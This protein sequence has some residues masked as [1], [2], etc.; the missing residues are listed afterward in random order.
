MLISLDWLKQYVDIKEDIKELDN[1][2]TMIGQE[3]EAIDIQGK[4]LD[5]VVI[6]HIVEY[7]KHPNSDKLT[8][9]KVNIGEEEPLQIVCGAPNHKLGDK[10]VV[11]KI[12][13]V[14]PG[15]FKIKKSKI[16]D[17]ESFGMLCSQVELGI[18]EDG[19]GII[20]LPEDAPIGVEY[21]KYAGL[22]DVI[23]EL[24]I[25]PNRPDCLSHIGIAREIAAYYGR[26]V[27]YPSVTYTEAIDP[28]TKV[29][30][31][32]IDDKDRCKRYMGRV[33]RN[34]TVGESPEWL[35]KRIRAMGLKP[36]NNV[37][38][39]T[40]FVMFEYN[41]PMHAFDL[42][43]VANGSIVV[44]EAK[45]GEK[46]T[47][48]DGVERELTNGEL[49]IADDE[50]AI[51]IAGIIGG[52]GTEITSETKNIFLEVAYFTPE[53]IRKTG[54]RLGISTDSSYRNERGIDIEGIP[55]ASERA[56]ALIAEIANGEI[57]DGAIDKYIEKPQ[58]YEIPLSL[59]KLNKFIGKEL[60]PDV[61]GKILSNLGLGIRT[62]SQDT[63]VV[64]P[65]TYR[66]D[67]TRTADIYEEIIRM[68][69]F[70]NIEPV[71][72]IKNIQ[73]GKKAENIDLI[74]NTK[75]ILREI[76]LQEVINYSFIPKNVVDI[77]NIKERV[78]EIK[79]PLSEDMAI[80][81]PTLMWSVLSNI[82]DNINRNQFDLRFCEV[83][84][85]FSPA[86]ELANEDLRVCI[87]LA[88][89]PE[90]TLWNPKPEAYDFYT[91]KG[92]V[93][94]LME[95]MGIARYKLERSTNS[96]FHPGRSAELRIGNDVIGVFGEIHPDVQE[97][98]EIKRERVYI[99]E[100]DLTKCVK[101]MK[102]SNKYEKIV[103]YPEVTRDLAIV[104]SK[105]VLVGNMI[106]S[107]KKVSPIIEKIDI[108]D[109]YEGDKIEANKKSVAISIVLRNKEKTLDEKEIN[110]AIEKILATISKDYNGEIRQ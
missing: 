83:S 76:G 108:F 46:I 48:L 12:G 77:L 35:K 104:L 11:A 39:I 85:V 96:N 92:Y 84:R 4:G 87:G 25:T 99:A 75:E 52:I 89:R 86:E 95:Y 58:K 71:M 100:I 2:L 68:Y 23:F 40:N 41:Q 78:I 36:I 44:R 79:N 32:N 80:L 34:V 47:T 21:R 57:L 65:P 31:V 29:A 13:A 81:R 6:G 64:I 28:T 50:K 106:E 56:M 49:V 53:N 59:E 54:R 97:K 67:L 61:V 1:A 7:G 30:K 3:V 66:G 33:I 102:N 42:D 27:K 5:N 17:V 22:D 38:D 69:G 91:I 14:L 10:V 101:Y 72:P 110:S 43:K 51:A 105:D 15:D 88:G 60:S 8:L 16:R 37:V 20:I 55:D 82:R 63:L 103:K 18:G 9:V 19:D 45:M 73:A 26:K 74:D 62:L 109:V 90:R 24:E 98:M 93:E 94:K 107:L 70:E